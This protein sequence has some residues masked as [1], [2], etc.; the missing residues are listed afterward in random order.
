[1]P[2]GVEGKSLVPVLRGR[3]DQVR[4][5]L[6]GAYREF[7]RSIREPRWKLIECRVEGRR[8]TQL[9]DLESDPCE[10]NNLAD[11]PNSQQHRQRLEGLLKQSLLDACDPVRFW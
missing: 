10:L 3:Q 4:D 6:V 9:F 2:E 11:N 1:V 8:S 5:F 7:Q